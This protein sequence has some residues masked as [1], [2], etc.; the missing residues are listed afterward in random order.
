MKN[1]FKHLLIL[2]R[3]ATGKSEFIDFIKK[4]PDSEREKKYHIGKFVEIDDFPWIWDKFMD[5]NIWEKIIGKRFF[6]KNYMPNNPGLC[7]EGAQL[8]DFCM[9]KFNEA[10]TSQYLSQPEFYN[11]HTL[12]IEFA[13]GREKA[14]EKALNL[15][16]PEI[17]KDS[18]IFFI[19]VTREESW[20]RNVARYQEK[21]R[22]S[23][24]AHMV[25]KETFDYFYSENDWATLT[26]NA[27][28][29]HLTIHGMKVPFVTMNNEPESTDPVV[30]EKR[31]GDA[32]RKLYETRSL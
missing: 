7:P 19:Q 21:Q 17:L 32:L 24:L 2:G 12:F 11:D 28:N 18:A 23:I 6:S 20:R 29:G 13:R 15:L 31:Y 5:D 22:H 26:N 27:P 14:F 10:I 25:P 3:P 16:K 4:V 30:L 1:I 9:E 8:F